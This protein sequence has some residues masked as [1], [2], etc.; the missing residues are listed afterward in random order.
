ML[1]EEV[2]R[3]KGNEVNSKEDDLNLFISSHIK[4]EYVKDEDVKIEIHKLINSI[5][6]EKD[7]LDIKRQ[8][9]DRFGK[10][11]FDLEVY[12]EE[13]LFQIYCKKLGISK[14]IDNNK[15]REIVIPINDN[16]NY[17]DLFLKSLTINN[18][19]KISYKNKKLIISLFYSKSKNKHVVFD[20]NRLLKELL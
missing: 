19:F 18:S 5:K 12:L 8:L 15:Y 17:E 1:N 14:V 13:E 16:F 20:Y 11:D 7:L 2:E 10:I 6:S 4:D 9:I 3:L